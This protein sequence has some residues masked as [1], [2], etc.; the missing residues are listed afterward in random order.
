[1]YSEWT[2]WTGPIPDLPN[3]GHYRP[4]HLSKPWIA[5]PLSKN[6][7]ERLR[8]TTNISR[9]TPGVTHRPG[10]SDT[11]IVAAYPNHVLFGNVYVDVVRHA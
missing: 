2:E 7:A 10:N 6:L 3:G 11:D 1:M 8:Q 4:P 5:K 9:T